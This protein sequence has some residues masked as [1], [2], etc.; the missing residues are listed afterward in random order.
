M[1]NFQ[2]KESKNIE[3]TCKIWD[4]CSEKALVKTPGRKEVKMGTD[5]CGVKINLTSGMYRQMRG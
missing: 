1:V 3:C 5:G 2:K 4:A